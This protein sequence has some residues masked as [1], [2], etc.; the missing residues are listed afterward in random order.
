MAEPAK[1]MEQL[2]SSNAQFGNGKARCD[3]GSGHDEHHS[4][5]CCC[6][7]HEDPDGIGFLVCP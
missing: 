6:C 3:Q 1:E 5:R 2:P 4:C 7:H